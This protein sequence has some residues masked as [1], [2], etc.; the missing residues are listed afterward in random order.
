M[1]MRAPVASRFLVIVQDRHVGQL[2][3]VY[4]NQ[5]GYDVKSCH[6]DNDALALLCCECHF[7]AALIDVP[8]P[9]HRALAIIRYIHRRRPEL[10][11]LVTTQ[12]ILDDRMMRK[13]E[14]GGPTVWL[15]NPVI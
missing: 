2:Y 3:S 1:T 14:R 7:D 5:L 6:D 13:L 4:L 11:I 9:P 10:P 12:S 8:F 15:F